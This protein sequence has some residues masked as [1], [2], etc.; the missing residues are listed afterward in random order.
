MS[1][2]TRFC[3][4]TG[5]LM[6]YA[7]AQ[8]PPTDLLYGHIEVHADYELPPAGSSIHSGWKLNVSYNKNDDFNDRTQ[9]VRMDPE[10]TVIVASPRTTQLANGNAITITSAVSRLG[11]VGSALWFFPQA[12]VLGTPFLG[13]RAVMDP[14]I[15]QVNFMG[16]YTPSVTG[17][18][19]LRL[20]S[21]TGTGPAA[22]GRFGLWESDG[23]TLLWYLDTSN[24]ITSADSIPTLPPN[25][26]SH[27]NWGFTKPGTYNL[28]LEASGRTNPNL[29]R[30]ANQLTSAQKT[31]RFSVPFSSRLQTQATIRLGLSTDTLRWHCLLEDSTNAVAYAPMQGFLE[32]ST[33][34]SSPVSS[35]LPGAVRQMPLTFTSAGS[36]VANIV[37]LEPAQA[38]AGL[39]TGILQGDQVKLTLHSHSGPGVFALLNSAGT[40]SLMTTA[41]G[42]GSGDSITLTGSTAMSTIAAF[43]QTGIHRVTFILS[44]NPSSGGSVRESAPFTLVFGSGVT[45]NHDYSTWRDS[46]ERAHGLAV[47]TLASASADFDKDGIVNGVEFLL[48][49]H[50]MDPVRSDAHLMPM[51]QRNTSAANFAFLRDTYKDAIVEGSYEI[52]AATSVDLISWTVRSPRVIGLPLE[53]YE[54][55]AEA[56]NAHGRIMQRRLRILTSPGQH[57]FFRFQPTFR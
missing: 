33:T 45:A 25:A 9:I 26:H 39:A 53:S 40:A 5:L 3:L 34:A 10:T 57:R 22:G 38:A 50:D 49:W 14:G 31:F 11:T 36:S 21:M 51:C 44:G 18:I 24:G 13:A 29:S 27:F 47:N 48:F 41:D 16:N 8:T 43:T 7:L 30:H 55:G 28:T 1:L 12:N 56:G 20:V 54:T 23:S 2:I 4:F 35:T 52:N 42:I 37:G 15:F 6:G 46:F 32:A 17:S 19:G